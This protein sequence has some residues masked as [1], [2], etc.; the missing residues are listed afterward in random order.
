MRAESPDGE[1]VFED[2]ELRSAEGAAWLYTVDWFERWTFARFLPGGELA[3]AFETGQPWSDWGS[4]GD[5]RGGVQVLSPS[6]TGWVLVAIEH[7]YRAHDESFVPHDICWSP[8]GVLA[9][10]RGSELCVIV[11]RSPRGEIVEDLLP[12][13][14]SDFAAYQFEVYGC[15]RSL[16][17]YDRGRLLIATDDE[18]VD[19]F[20]LERRRRKRGDG[21]WEAF[22]VWE[23]E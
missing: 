21:G 11:L 2:G 10:L 7:D 3:L 5:R 6:S 13:C 16:A 15:W 12:E 8:H 9:W 18:G 23:F 19:L 14:D 20:D 17:I 22:D 4:Y 1:W